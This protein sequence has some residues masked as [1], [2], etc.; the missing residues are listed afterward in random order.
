MSRVFLMKWYH[1]TVEYFEDLRNVNHCE[2]LIMRKQ[3]DSGKY[4]LENKL[5]T[6]SELRKERAQ[7][8]KEKEEKEKTKDKKEEK[9]KV[10]TPKLERTK[11][12]IVTRRWGGCPNGCN[13]G[14][15]YKR[16][17]DLEVLRQRD[18]TG[19]ETSSH[20]SNGTGHSNGTSVSASSSIAGRRPGVKR[21]HLNVDAENG[22]KHDHDHGEISSGDNGPQIDVT[23][24][25][26]E[27]VS[28]PDGTPSFISAEDRLRSLKSPLLPM[29]H[30]PHHHLHVGRDFGGTYSG[31]A[32]LAGSDT[33]LSDDDAVRRRLAA[34]AA[35]VKNGT[36][37]GSGPL[38]QSEETLSCHDENGVCRHARANRLG[39]APHSSSDAGSENEADGEPDIDDDLAQAEK[40]DKSI[41][42]SVY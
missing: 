24:A 15:H 5:R 22:H 26:E 33:D 28:S 42:G 7:A 29:H 4:I 11:T 3:E 14:S 2:F 27:V 12:F 39:D 35:R 34:N 30:H 17:D 37:H 21:F 16:R 25:R 41:E 23:R 13:H 1:F 20:Q 19:S 10:D 36:S 18:I 9:D 32:S 31:H 8:V 6:W 38:A 40:K